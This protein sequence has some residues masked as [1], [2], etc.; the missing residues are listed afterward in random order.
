MRLWIEQ[1]K[2]ADVLADQAITVAYSYIGPE[3]TY[4]IYKEGSIGQAKKHLYQTADELNEEVDGLLAYVSVNKAVVTQ[5][6][7]AIPIVP[8][9]LSLLFKVMK[10][11][12]LHEDCIKQMYRLVHDRLCCKEIPT[13]QNRLIRVDDYEMK[14]EVQ[15]AVAKLWDKVSKDNIKEI[16][17]LD[18]YWDEF[19]EIFG[20]G[21][22]GVDYDADVAIQIPIPSLDE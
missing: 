22:D 17:D 9:Y 21:I 16:A 11:K 20:F 15:E 3:I 19:Y 5:S 6:S 10:E 7:A 4:P 1:L 14:P 8:L 13:D 12:G 18:G 2:A